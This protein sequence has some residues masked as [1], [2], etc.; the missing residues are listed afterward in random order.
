MKIFPLTFLFLAISCGYI[1]SKKS[2][3]D[4]FYDLIPEATK[5]TSG[6]PQNSNFIH[7]K[8]LIASDIQ[9]W[10]EYFLKKDRARFKRF[11]VNGLRY[12]SIIQSILK[13]HKLPAE[14]FYLGLIESGYYT[15]AHSR[16]SAHGPWQFIRS[17]ARVYGLTMNPHID[18][19]RSVFKATHAAAMYLSDLYNIFGSWELALAA[20]NAGENKIIRI[21]RKA[22]T[23]SFKSLLER[24]LLPRET[25]QY[26]P[27]LL[28]A[29]ELGENW[30]TQYGNLDVDERWDVNDFQSLDLKKSVNTKKLAK[31][32]GVNHKQF[33]RWNPDIKGSSIYARRNQEFTVYY[34]GDE[35]DSELLAAVRGIKSIKLRS[36]ASSKS[37]IYKVRRGDVLSTIARKFR[38]SLR[39]LI[40][41]NRLSMKSMLR[42]GQKLRIPDR[43]GKSRKTSGKTYKVRRGDNLFKIAR[44]FSVTLKKLREVNNLSQSTIYP[45]QHLVIPL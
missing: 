11:L 15:S 26:V 9:R 18:E 33:K 36:Y 24:K 44:R 1:D 27:K 14:L 3:K 6:P 13:E 10:R 12:K 16:A 39:R 29:M 28:A 20:Y 37:S 35:K 2:V 19:R 40:K 4:P 42:I 41:T 32:L 45:R 22:N 23:R 30:E 17:T 43:R 7:A 34:E 21:I 31:V 38:V 25:V 5:V 8:N